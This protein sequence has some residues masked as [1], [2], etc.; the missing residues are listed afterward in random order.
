MGCILGAL[1]LSII[2]TNYNKAA[3]VAAAVDSALGQTWRSGPEGKDRVE[4]IVVDDGSSD[5]S[6]AVLEQYKRQVTLIRKENGGQASA[7]NAGF[8]VSSGEVV[9]FLDSDDMLLPDTAERVAAVWSQKTAKV[10]FRL[11]KITADGKPLGGALLPP[12]RALPS[13]DLRPMLWQFGFYPSPPT[14]GNAFARRFLQQVMPIAET[15]WRAADTPLIGAAP[16]F[17]E[18]GVLDGIGGFWRRHEGN[19]S[20]VGIDGLLEDL[21]FDQ[22]MIQFLTDLHNRITSESSARRRF[23]ANWPGHLKEQLI[24]AKF[25]GAR[26]RPRSA[27]IAQIAGAYLAAVSRWPE[28]GPVTRMRFVGWGIAIGVL[29]RAFLAKIPGIA[30]RSIRL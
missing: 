29:P 9:L 26:G 15:Y 22:H 14:T 12:Y 6:L 11:Q 8:A 24:V 10:H 18:I 4:V 19:S 5:T 20:A 2:V 27:S 25:G 23:R 28:Y 30:G 16:L 17:G 3:Y 21:S 7:M 1:T 13:G